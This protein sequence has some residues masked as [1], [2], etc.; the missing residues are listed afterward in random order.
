MKASAF[1]RQTVDTLA[2]RSGF[3]CANPD[4]GI[5]T[6]GPNADPNKA[7]TIGEAAHICGAKL[8]SM[9]Y[10]ATMSDVT[11]AS[12]TNGIWLCK[13]CHGKIDR[14][15]IEYPVELL[16]AW[17]KAHE[18]RVQRELEAVGIASAMKWRWR[19]YIF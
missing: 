3:Q 8:G 6:V 11:R 4:C 18:E 5:Q 13:N 10:D 9:R 12:I 19:T 17:R 15:A 16:F 14:D 1:S 2:R 7:T